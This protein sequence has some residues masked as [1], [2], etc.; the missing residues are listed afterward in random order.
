MMNRECDNP[1]HDGDTIKGD[2]IIECWECEE[3]ALDR[4][5]DERFEAMR[6]SRWD[7]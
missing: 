6:D 2:Q 1:D 5:E 7:D 4:A 3:E